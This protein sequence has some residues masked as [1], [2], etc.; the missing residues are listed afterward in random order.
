VL[1]RVVAAAFNQRR[2]M[3]RA[4]LKGQAPDIE[5]RLRA[6]GIEPTTRAEDVP[7]EAILRAGARTRPR[8]GPGP[9]M[10]R[11]VWI[12]THADVVI[13]PAVPVPDWGLSPRGTAR[14]AALA[15]TWARVRPAPDAVWSSTERKAHEGAAPIAQAFG[16]SVRTDADLGENDRSATGFIPEP[17]FSRVAEAFF[18]R[19][20][21]SVRGWERARDAQ[22]RIVA[23]G[24]QGRRGDA[25]LG[26]YRHRHPW[27][28]G[29]APAVRAAWSGHR[30]GPRPR[31]CGRRRDLRDRRGTGCG[32]A[33]APSRPTTRW[34]SE[35][36]FTPR[37]RAAGRHRRRLG[38]PL[39]AAL[40]GTVLSGAFAVALAGAAG[41]AAARF[42]RVF[43]RL[44]E[45]A[46]ILVRLVDPL[47]K[48]VDHLVERL[49]V[50][51]HSGARSAVA[52]A[53]VLAPVLLVVLAPVL[54]VVLRLILVPV[55]VPPDHGSG[56]GS[57]PDHGSA[58]PD[59]G[60]A[61]V[62]VPV[63]IPVLLL[64]AL[65]WSRRASI[66]RCASAS[67]RR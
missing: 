35:G 3:L 31:I 60:P 65:P 53:P 38:G 23:G 12:V 13:D 10:S 1:S 6:A 15:G 67:M 24:G 33:G 41:A 62:L 7:L 66:S 16:L 45:G 61:A 48:L 25:R 55:L 43:R 49:G 58:G 29:D 36:R 22:A 51:P 44:D 14:H 46:A 18:D 8:S 57:G 4:A 27:R 20:D 19:P 54:V 9:L 26:G 17:E 34:T 59:P 30:S 21:E 28:G 32:A 11:L 64:I 56:S 42:G 63:L 50:P 2:K 52:L 40:A 37:P 5:D 39:P 47:S